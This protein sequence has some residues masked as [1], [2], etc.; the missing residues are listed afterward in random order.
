MKQDQDQDAPPAL[1]Y[2]HKDGNMY[3]TQL[4]PSAL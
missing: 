2:P 4:I 1:C 3:Q